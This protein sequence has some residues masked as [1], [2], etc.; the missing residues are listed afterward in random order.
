MPGWRAGCARHHRHSAGPAREMGVAVRREAVPGAVPVKRRERLGGMQGG[1]ER[2]GHGA[3]PERGASGRRWPPAWQSL[4]STRR[5]R[6]R[7]TGSSNGSVQPRAG[8]HRELARHPLGCGRSPDAAGI[9]C[10]PTDA[11]PAAMKGCIPPV[12]TAQ[13]TLLETG[14]AADSIGALDQIGWGPI[15]FQRL[16]LPFKSIALTN[17]RDIVDTRPFGATCAGLAAAVTCYV[18][19]SGDWLLIASPLAVMSAYYLFFSAL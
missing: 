4:I 3:L 18:A 17:M 19:G 8:D 15:P 14:C 6:G 11:A 10:H 2:D 5:S 1:D 16:P 12:H 7:S 9:Q 13:G